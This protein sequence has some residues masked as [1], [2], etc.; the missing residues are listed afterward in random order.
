MDVSVDGPSAT[1][2]REN[3][4]QAKPPSHRKNG[5]YGRAF[6]KLSGLENSNLQHDGIFLRNLDQSGAVD[7]AKFRTGQFDRGAGALR[8][9]LWV[10][11]SFVLFRLCPFKLSALKRSVLRAFGA[12]VGQGVVIK[13]RV[14]ITF[15]WKLTLGDNVWLGEECWLLNLDQ[16]AIGSNVCLSQRAFLC[17]GNHDYESTSFDL[18]IRPIRVEEGAWVGAH[19]WIGPGVCVGTHAVV[20][21]GSVVTKDLTPFGIYRGNPAVLVKRR[22]LQR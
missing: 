8:E 7:L 20:C 21:A 18:I 4:P 3:D 17:T 14:V 5:A 13:P 9:G 22:Q 11:T 6:R 15:P 19:A 16:I 12:K 2:Q 10:L 1:G